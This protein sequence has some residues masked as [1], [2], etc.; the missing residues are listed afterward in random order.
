MIIVSHREDASTRCLQGLRNVVE[1]VT[2]ATL[3]E[4]VE[5]HQ[6]HED[7]ELAR[8]IARSWVRIMLVDQ[9]SQEY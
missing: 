1:A 2:G 9:D 8:A 4:T 5:H 7:D 6:R 3:E